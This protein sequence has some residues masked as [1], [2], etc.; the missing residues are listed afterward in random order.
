[1]ISF[2]QLPA[3][4]F[5][6][7][8]VGVCWFHKTIPNDHLLRLVAR[9]TWVW[10]SWRWFV[11][12]LP[13]CYASCGSVSL[14][15]LEG[16]H[17]THLPTTSKLRDI[18][19]K[20]VKYLRRKSRFPNLTLDMS[21]D[22]PTTRMIWTFPFQKSPT[23]LNHEQNPKQKKRQKKTILKQYP[24]FFNKW[25]VI[26]L[27]GQHQTFCFMFFPK[28]ILSKLGFGRSLLASFGPLPKARRG[29][30]GFGWRLNLGGLRW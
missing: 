12:S 20:L 18:E 15:G 5:M 4:N 7:W 21:L 16:Q 27:F 11:V 10:A 14:P 13:G 3:G 1:M 19:G 28:A 29:A 26:L 25:S 2:T 6:V 23:K 24:K 9:R 30:D 17:A 8:W 22:S